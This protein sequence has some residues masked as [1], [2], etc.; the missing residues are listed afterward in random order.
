VDPTS[1]LPG[2]EVSLCG[3]DFWICHWGFN[4]V[5]LF[6]FI[7]V[8]CW[9]LIIFPSTETNCEFVLLLLLWFSGKPLIRGCLLCCDQTFLAWSKS[10]DVKGPLVYA[11]Y[12]RLEDFEWVFDVLWCEH[13]LWS[14]VPHGF[15]VRVVCACVCIFF[16]VHNMGIIVTKEGY[17]H[18]GQHC[19]CAIRSNLPWQQGVCFSHTR[20]FVCYVFA[21]F[22]SFVMIRKFKKNMLDSFLNLKLCWE[23]CDADTLPCHFCFFFS[24]TIQIFIIIFFVSLLTMKTRLNWQSNSER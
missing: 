21:F 3:S 4:F 7:K 16:V 11:N 9:F 14:D 5:L 19:H 6:Y 2:V 13:V 8:L 1:G 15:C 10:G 24:K 18:R 12:G 20:G 17:H 23:E 22:L